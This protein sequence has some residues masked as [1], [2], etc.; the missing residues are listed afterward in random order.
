MLEDLEEASS[1]AT[2]AEKR[3][4]ELTEG[5]KHRVVALRKAEAA[6]K[7]EQAVIQEKEEFIREQLEEEQPRCAK[8]A[9][10]M[11]R[12]ADEAEAAWVADARRL[13]G[14]AQDRSDRNQKGVLEAMRPAL[15]RCGFRGDPPWVS[16][17]AYISPPATFPDYYEVWGRDNA[18]QGAK[19][20]RKITSVPALV[21]YLERA[22]ASYARLQNFDVA[23]DVSAHGGPRWRDAA[24]DATCSNTSYRN[25][26][27][28][29]LS[30]SSF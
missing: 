15:T 22:L 2:E 7:K 13:L 8:K 23:D 25:Y 18:G 20:Q 28:V 10:V 16:G 21:G 6:R 12:K 29:R 26:N 4:A 30:I 3:A 24:G 19:G 27:D 9:E 14:E 17:Q 1:R 11:S 5:R